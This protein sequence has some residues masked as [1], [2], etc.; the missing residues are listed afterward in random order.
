MLAA[1][2][3]TYEGDRMRAKN[4]TSF[5]AAIKGEE[6]PA[7]ENERK[8][9]L[10]NATALSF[11]IGA[12]EE[13]EGVYAHVDS[14]VAFSSTNR[15]VYG[16]AVVADMEGGEYRRTVSLADTAWMV[17]RRSNKFFD[18]PPPGRGPRG[19]GR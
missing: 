3:V 10:K 12:T 6:A 14:E 8:S 7:V 5:R 19:P 9:V 4:L 11:Q 2:G 16:S 17:A 13:E 18:N 1:L 15:N